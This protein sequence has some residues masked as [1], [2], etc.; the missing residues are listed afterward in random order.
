MN[1]D[2]AT[3]AAHSGIGCPSRIPGTCRNRPVKPVI[4]KRGVKE[5]AMKTG[6]G[7]DGRSGLRY[8]C[9]LAGRTIMTECPT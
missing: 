7:W 1:A 2:A 5:T 6:W 3:S 8:V 4:R 9:V